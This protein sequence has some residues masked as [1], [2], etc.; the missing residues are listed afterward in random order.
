MDVSYIFHKILKR[1]SA[2]KSLYRSRAGR[3]FYGTENKIWAGFGLVG[4]TEKQIGADHE[5]LLRSVFSCLQG[6]KI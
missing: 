4:N 6:Q 3:L 1:L 2:T 5:Q